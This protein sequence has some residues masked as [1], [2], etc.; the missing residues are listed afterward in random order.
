MQ[1]KE[2]GRW[3]WKGW[4]TPALLAYTPTLWEGGLRNP[5]TSW[6]LIADT[7]ASDSLLDLD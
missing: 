5:T 3:R 2:E 1:G 4:I 7:T 6:Q